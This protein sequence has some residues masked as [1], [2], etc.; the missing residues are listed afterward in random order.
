MGSCL[1]LFLRC[2]FRIIFILIRYVATIAMKAF[3]D[4]A[5]RIAFKQCYDFQPVSIDWASRPHG[6]VVSKT[7]HSKTKTKARS[8]QISK[9]KHPKLENE[10]PKTRNRSVLYNTR[11]TRSEKTANTNGNWFSSCCSW[12]FVWILM[13]CLHFVVV[14]K[15]YYLLYAMWFFLSLLSISTGCAASLN[16]KKRSTNEDKF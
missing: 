5:L 16:N 9:T 4:E 3:Y 11:L 12:N 8:T 1:F 13:R 6:M 15:Y 14:E 2:S 7:K 10:A